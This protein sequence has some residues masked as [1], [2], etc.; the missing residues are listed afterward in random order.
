MALPPTEE[1]SPLDRQNL[2][3]LE[4]PPPSQARRI[5]IETIQTIVLAV[6]LFLAINFLSARIRVDGSSME[7]NFHNG[8]Y[9]IVNRVAYQTGDIQRGDVVVFPYPRNEEVDYIKRVIGLPGDQVAIYG[10][11]VYLNGE[12]VPETYVLEP[13]SFDLA[14]QAVP[15]GTVFVLGDNRNNSED[16]RSWGFLSIE[17]IIGKAIFRYWPFDTMGV[18]YHPDIVLAAPQS[19]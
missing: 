8:D 19:N 5:I 12:A 11:V 18:V 3:N 1:I 13:W 9:V 4:T 15:E 14:E 6:V 17:K 10:G 7:P 16:S 2:V